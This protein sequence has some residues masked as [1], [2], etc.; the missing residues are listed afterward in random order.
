MREKKNR[1]A[2]DMTNASMFEAMFRLS[3]RMN[4]VRQV[5]EGICARCDGSGAGE[6]LADL[7]EAFSRGARVPVREC[8]SCSGT[9]MRS[10][11][12]EVS[13]LGILLLF[14]IAVAMYQNARRPDAR[15][16][17]VSPVVPA[18]PTTSE[19]LSLMD[20]IDTDS[21]SVRPQES[22]L[23]ASGV[24]KQPVQ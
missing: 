1:R 24:T 15:P 10:A 8:K 12:V 7:G 11:T 5:S 18:G 4:A 19:L 2:G 13:P 3:L 21:P 22:D 9:G 14:P 17:I 23:T 20:A 6:A 16:A